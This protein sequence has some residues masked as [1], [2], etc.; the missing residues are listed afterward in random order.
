MIVNI[1]VVQKH[2][3]MFLLWGS[4]VLMHLGYATRWSSG[5]VLTALCR[6]AAGVVDAKSRDQKVILQKEQK[7]Q[8]SF[9][10]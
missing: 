6:A 4:F 8:D 3:F 7:V 9:V 10:V 2:V 1:C 5:T